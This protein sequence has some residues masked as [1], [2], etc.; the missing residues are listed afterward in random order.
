M[1]KLFRFK[2]EPCEGTCYAWC[3]Y[4]PAQLNM[5]SEQERKDIIDLMVRAHNNLCD[6]P[7]F[8]FGIDMDDEMNMFVSHFRTPEKTNV[9]LHK[10]FNSCVKEICLIVLNE[11]IPQTKGQ[12]NYGDNG[13]EN[14]GK[15]ILRACQDEIYREEHHKNCPCN[16]VA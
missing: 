8:S 4:L 3:D 10:T 2:Y 15:E 6:N 11:K 16:N 9:Y 5:L 7:D 14:L 12:C 13:S 1:R